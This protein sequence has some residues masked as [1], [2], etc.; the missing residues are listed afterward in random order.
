M[1]KNAE[2][3]AA[4]QYDDLLCRC[5]LSDTGTIPRTAPFRESPDVIPVG[6]KPIDDPQTYFSG[7]YDQNVAQTVYTEEANLIYVRGRNLKELPQNGDIYVYWARQSDID[8]PS[9]WKGNQLMTV[10]GHGSVR[11]TDVAPQAIV[12]GATAF[13]W[14]P[15]AS[16]EEASVVLI[17]VLAT[18][19]HPN[20]VPDLNPI[21]LW[22][23]DSWVAKKGG[24][25]AF[26]TTV[27]AK[28]KPKSTVKLKGDMKF[29][30]GGLGDVLI[31]AADMP[32]GSI[33]SLT[34][35]TPVDGKT[36]SIP[37]TKITA[38][39]Q[40]FGTQA[41]FP[42]GYTASIDSTITVIGIPGLNN[43]VSARFQYTPPPPAGTGG[44]VRPVVIARYSIHFGE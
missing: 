21:L 37:P 11:V 15:D 2:T 27:K 18:N 6:T 16:F 28:P 29:A 32:L 42:A 13:T 20:P 12:A 30:E 5:S 10:D 14:T 19:D 23:F 40:T 22:S 8:H 4:Y 36:V 25:G 1:V 31:T 3:E 17:G 38:N 41:T 7:N 26:Q 33:V 35:S 24:V 43:S 39:P 9:R 34:L 44:P